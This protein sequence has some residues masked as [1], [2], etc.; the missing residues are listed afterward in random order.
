MK[1]GNTIDAEHRP[2]AELREGFRKPLMDSLGGN[3]VVLQ[4]TRL[5]A[6]YKNNSLNAH[7]TIQEA[8]IVK[9]KDPF[10]PAQTGFAYNRTNDALLAYKYS[11]SGMYQSLLSHQHHQAL[12][13]NQFGHLPPSM[14][15]H[16]VDSQTDLLQKLIRK[17]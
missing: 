12:F 16:H 1:P 17:I 9:Y 10:L 15:L 3:A 5:N 14:G 11:T 6:A 7:L 4:S 2:R 8:L 13:V